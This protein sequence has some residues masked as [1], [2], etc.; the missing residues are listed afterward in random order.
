MKTLISGLTVTLLLALVL[1]NASATFA[2]FGWEDPQLCV[3][4]ELLTVVPAEPSDVSVTLPLNATYDTDVAS[5]GGDPTQG[6]ITNV[7]KK[8]NG[9]KMEV[10]VQTTPGTVVTFAY[11]GD[12][13][14]RSSGGGKVKV[15]FDLDD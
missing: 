3:N 12:T 11:N 6:V 4:G 10:T 1:I 15:K 13:E 14:T 5:C 7:T 9:H 2:G 8:G